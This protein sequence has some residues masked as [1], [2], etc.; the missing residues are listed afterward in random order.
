MIP[1]IPASILLVEGIRTH[2]HGNAEQYY[3]NCPE[4]FVLLPG[5]V[6]GRD[7]FVLHVGFSDM[8]E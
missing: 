7:D 6:D 8:F 5:A 2:V 4:F 1:E 3:Y